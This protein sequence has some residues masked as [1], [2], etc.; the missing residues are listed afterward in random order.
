M[1]Q[2]V[3]SRLFARHEP[4][5]SLPSPYHHQP[6]SHHNQNHADIR[7]QH[8]VVMRVDANVNVAGIESVVFSVGNRDEEGE[9]PENDDY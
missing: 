4:S 6:S 7:R 5:N 8:L 1:V 9:N 3:V 2:A